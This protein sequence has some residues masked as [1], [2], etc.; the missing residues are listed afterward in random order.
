MVQLN[1]KI[2]VQY[3]LGGSPRSLFLLTQSRTENTLAA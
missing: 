1:Y 3:E 2:G